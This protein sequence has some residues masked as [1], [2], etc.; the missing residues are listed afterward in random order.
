[1][2]CLVAGT[3]AV[4]LVVVLGFIMTD[5]DDKGEPNLDYIIVQGAQVRDQGPSVVRRYR[6]DTAYDYLIENEQTTC[7]VSGGRGGNESVSEAQVMAQ[8]L[9]DRGIS[10]ERIIMEDKSLNTTENIENS[11]AFIDARSDSVGIV[12]NNFHMHR[13][14]SIARKKGIEHACG[15][16]APSKTWYLPNNMLRE[17][18]GVIKDKAFGNM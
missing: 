9:T 6:L 7:I 10:P 14:L 2:S 5:F 8:Y 3:V 16:A 11:M 17:A 13:G 12:T 4:V 18:L 15:I 1:G